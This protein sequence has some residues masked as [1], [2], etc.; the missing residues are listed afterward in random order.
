MLPDPT[1][2][3]QL[4]PQDTDQKEL[5]YKPVS[6]VKPWSP[7]YRARGKWFNERNLTQPEHQFC[8]LYLSGETAVEAAK[9]SFRIN[10]NLSPGRQDGIAL[11][12]ARRCLRRARVVKF[13]ESNLA[14]SGFNDLNVDIQH[15]RLINQ[16]GNPT[17]KL[18]AIKH[19]NERKG[20]VAP[21][22][23]EQ[24]IRLAPTE[25]ASLLNAQRPGSTVIDVNPE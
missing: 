23:S 13:L 11:A 24:T 18:A 14:V 16:D 21:T 6:E 17:I 5:V 2:F 7:L 3:N 8:E 22:K 25:L 10:P 12:K 1:I 19:F 20:R 4:T 15:S 9:Q